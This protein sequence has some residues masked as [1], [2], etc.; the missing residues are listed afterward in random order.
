MVSLQSATC[1]LLTLLEGLCH[2]CHR[3]ISH[4]LWL[5]G[6]PGLISFLNEL[7]LLVLTN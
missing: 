4:G 6:V 2:P 3:A 7:I 5:Q 1:A